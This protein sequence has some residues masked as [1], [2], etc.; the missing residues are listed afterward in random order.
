MG[1][2]LA[3]FFANLF[4]YHCE[5]QWLLNL[6]KRAV[7]GLSA[8]FLNIVIRKSQKNNFFYPERDFPSVKFFQLKTILNQSEE[9]S[10]NRII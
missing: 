3:P 1:S 6:N 8:N 9:K 5:R 7:L 10:K 2:D 4:L